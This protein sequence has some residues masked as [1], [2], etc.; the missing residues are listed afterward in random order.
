MQHLLPEA[1]RERQRNMLAAAE[2][3]REGYR[4]LRRRRIERLAARAERRALSHTEKAAALRADMRQL[5]SV[6]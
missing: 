5:E 3:E 6:M 2:A 4:A 1:A